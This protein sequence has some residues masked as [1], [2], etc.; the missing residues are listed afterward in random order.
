M[1]EL[2]FL[3]I[4]WLSSYPQLVLQLL[5]CTLFPDEI[6]D[7][8]RVVGYVDKLYEAIESP[9]S[10]WIPAHNRLRKY[11]YGYK[12]YQALDTH[13]KQDKRSEEY[14]DT[15]NLLLERGDGIKGIIS[16]SS[17]YL[18]LAIYSARVV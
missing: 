8:K 12:L 13:L 14:T 6:V 11:F 5:L 4:D 3:L 2:K 10:S 1:P 17:L 7:D 15:V 16:V 9:G 18:Q